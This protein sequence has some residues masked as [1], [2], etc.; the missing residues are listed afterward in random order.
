M[1][2]GIPYVFFLWMSGLRAA[3]KLSAAPRWPNVKFAD[4]NDDELSNKFPKFV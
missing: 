3:P 1:G 4:R 2:C